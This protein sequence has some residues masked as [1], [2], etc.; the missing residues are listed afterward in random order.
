MLT[1]GKLE[2]KKEC[3]NKSGSTEDIIVKLMSEESGELS[4]VTD[5]CLKRLF[6]LGY[7]CSKT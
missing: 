4:E 5:R 7:V 3:I 2:K 1:I 6:K